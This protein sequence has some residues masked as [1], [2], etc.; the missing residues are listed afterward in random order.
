ME[1]RSNSEFFF[2]F[3]WLQDLRSSSSSEASTTAAAEFVP[4]IRSGSFADI[5]PRKDM[6]DEHIR[7]DDLAA[8]M[9]SIFR[10]PTPSAFYGV[11][12]LTVAAP[13]ARR[14]RP[15]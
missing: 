5:G 4:F 13:S 14:R 6:E 11:S 9:G 2:F 3:F 12:S 8:H 15:P 1:R 7:V 10:C